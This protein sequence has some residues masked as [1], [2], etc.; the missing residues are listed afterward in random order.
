MPRILGLISAAFA[1]IA[2]ALTPST[3]ERAT[4]PVLCEGLRALMVASTEIRSAQVEDQWKA[5]TPEHRSDRALPSFC[6]IVGTVSPAIDSAIR[7]EVWMPV[8][9]WNGKIQGL[10]NAGFGGSNNDGSVSGEF[11]SRGYAVSF[12]DTGHGESGTS[13]ALGHPEQVV[14]F[15]YRAIHETAVVAKALTTAFYGSPAR[16]AYFNSCSTGGRQG[17]MEAQR[18]P[19]DYDGIVSGAPA[20]DYTHMMVQWLWNADRVADP[21]VRLT[22]EKLAMVDAAMVAAC[23]AKDGVADGV[24]ENPPSCGFDPGVLLCN[25]AETETCLTEPQVAAVK[26]LHAGPATQAA[27]TIYPGPAVASVNNGAP[28]AIGFFSHFVFE[29]DA[30]DPRSFDL[31]LERD[32]KAADDKLAATINATDPDLR[33]FAARGG[34]LLMYHGWADGTVSPAS[35]IDYYNSVVKKMG[36]MATDDMLR[37]FMAPGMEHCAGGPGPNEFGQTFVAQKDADHD[38]SLA[39]ERWVEQRKAPSSIVATH[40]TGRS[41]SVERTRPLCPYPQVAKWNGAG[42]TDEAQNFACVAPPR[43]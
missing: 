30:W 29:D 27:A 13:W 33:R 25:S 15:G 23:D 37:L 7:F 22:P 36:R 10:G 28:F 17:L 38:I 11:L 39:L 40:Y 1:L 12:T 20:N 21:E 18:Y 41:D 19:G 4:P 5:P 42:S 9:G 2:A 24:I 32:A 31:D 8:T 16:H 35:T 26:K 14:D 3:P 6:R 43:K 34:K